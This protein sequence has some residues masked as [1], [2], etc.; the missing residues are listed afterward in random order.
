MP[1]PRGPQLPGK[2]THKPHCGCAECR[3]CRREAKAVAL[4]TGVPAPVID[5]ILYEKDL[6]NAPLIIARPHQTIRSRIAAWLALRAVEPRIS[7]QEASRRMGLAPGYLQQVISVAVKEGWLK[8]DDPLDTIEH[9]LIPKTLLNLNT[10][11]DAKDRTTTLEMAKGTVFKTYAASK[12][13]SEAPQTVLALKIETQDHDQVKV[14][15]GNVVGK[16]REAE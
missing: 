16:P 3:A 10:L 9:Q 4:A 11:L 14:F 5:E 2:P 8:F 7:T 15:A 6:L 1:R 12:G 13:A